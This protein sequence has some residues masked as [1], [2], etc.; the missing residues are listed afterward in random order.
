MLQIVTM[1]V[2]AWLRKSECTPR[3][4][5]GRSNRLHFL[6]FLLLV[7]KKLLQTPGLVFELLPKSQLWLP[8]DCDL[9][10]RRIGRESCRH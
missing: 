10:K 7:C 6:L 1:G 3:L 9:P 2:R 8:P 4:C 5:L